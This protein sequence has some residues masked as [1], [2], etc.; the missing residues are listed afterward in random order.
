MTS[1]KVS[2]SH[3]MS[4]MLLPKGVPLLSR[5]QGRCR[6]GRSARRWV[7]FHPGDHVTVQRLPLAG[8]RSIFCLLPIRIRYI[9]ADHWP[10]CWVEMA[11]GIDTPSKLPDD[12]AQ[13]GTQMSLIY[14]D[15]F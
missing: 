3:C 5:G 12:R 1:F 8:G 15:I 7:T 13:L 9:E 2:E 11:W 4:S 10:D 14:S 6:D